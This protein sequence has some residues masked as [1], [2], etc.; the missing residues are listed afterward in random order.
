M[1]I[2]S[3]DIGG[4][5]TRLALW[6]SE[7]ERLQP[8]RESKFQ[9]GEHASLG[10]IVLKFLGGSRDACGGACFG[11]PGPVKKG[12]ARTTNL[13]WLV[14]AREL[15]EELGIERVSLLNDLEAH[16]YGIA[17]LPEDEYAM[18]NSCALR[19]VSRRAHPIHGILA[20]NE[21]G[22]LWRKP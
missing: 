8:V 1:Q 14:E 9:S 17:A 18:T 2:L 15:S 3:G 5:N 12:V 19:A 10:E 22:P 7:G 20:H 16:A 4:T 13:P 6:E 11:I 21:N